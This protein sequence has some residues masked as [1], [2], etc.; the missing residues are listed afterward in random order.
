ML[1]SIR[2]GAYFIKVESATKFKRISSTPLGAST[3]VG[4]SKLLFDN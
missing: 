4:I 1:V 2:S 3:F